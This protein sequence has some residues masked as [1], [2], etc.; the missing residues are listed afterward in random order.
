MKEKMQ[1]LFQKAR[2]N[3][4]EK[5]RILLQKAREDWR[6][7]LKSSLISLFAVLFWGIFLRD[8]FRINPENEEVMA[9][10]VG[11]FLVFSALLPSFTLSRLSSQ[12]DDLKVAIDIE[13]SFKKFRILYKK[14]V[15]R[16]TYQAM[17]LVSILAILALMMLP[18]NRL[19]VGLFAVGGLTF[20][21]SFFYF[22]AKEL[23][24]PSSW[25]LKIPRAWVD[26]LK[27]E[28]EKRVE[29]E[30]EDLK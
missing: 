4:K 24:D 5:R 29:E 28:D 27:K 3:M 10:V 17:I 18:Y 22:V 25:H 2:E 12:Y 19:V 26:R 11:G 15:H 14:A 9:A 8:N 23:D 30:W 20:V 7:R 16:L 6:I 13:K 21:H 1:I